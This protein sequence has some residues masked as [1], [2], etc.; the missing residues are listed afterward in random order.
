[1]FCSKVNEI[2][3][4]GADVTVKGL[5]GRTPVQLASKPELLELL[6]QYESQAAAARA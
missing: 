1:M 6:K 5:D 3:K 2:L 4:A